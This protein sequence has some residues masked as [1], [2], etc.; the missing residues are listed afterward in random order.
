M[1]LAAKWGV[2]RSLIIYYGQPWK[3]ARMRRFYAQFVSS[4]DLCVDVGAHVGN[5]I[6]AW[7][8][9]GA[10]AVA[11]EPQ[12]RMVKTLER[13][14]GSDPQV[15]IMPVG[16]SDRPGELTLHVNSRNPTITSFSSDWVEAF[17]RMESAPFDEDVA[18]KV[19]T[20]DE[21]IAQHGVPDHHRAEAWKYM[22]GVSRS[23]R[24]EEMSIR[25]RMDN[26][27]KE[28]EKAWRAQPNGELARAVKAEVQPH[29]KALGQSLPPMIPRD[30][31]RDA[32][33]ARLRK[34]FG[35]HLPKPGS[36]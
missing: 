7:R 8:A 12:P 28:L 19:T 1:S 26:E 9:L 4:G 21:L 14:F 10:H 31:T 25:K 18:V 5:R 3:T 23:E 27:H 15:T 29:R 20:L 6:R 11:V 30:F 34:I 35:A 17:S 32:Y 16:L 36:C 33:L 2:T 22:L 24:A 13:F